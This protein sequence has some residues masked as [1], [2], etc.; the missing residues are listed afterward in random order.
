MICTIGYGAGNLASVQRAINHLGYDTV[1][2]ESGNEIPSQTT[3]IILPGVGDGSFMMQ[4]LKTRGFVD[5]LITW[6]QE[7]K[8]LLGICVGAQV[9]LSFT[10]EGNTDCLGLIPG[11]CTN[12]TQYIDATQIAQGLKIPHMGWNSINITKQ[13]SLFDGVPNYSQ[14]YFVH[15]YFL[16]VEDDA[17]VYATTE[18]GLQY[19]SVIGTRKT[20]GVQF[21]PEKSG[22]WGLKILD[23]FLTHYGNEEK[24]C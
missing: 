3:S 18:Y 11:K 5:Q 8:P 12:F 4:Q 14:V 7:G 19:A 24:S 22:K 6:T 2:A 23:N 13:D 20:I 10:E 1:V 21:H 16:L 17:Y 15:S 9:L